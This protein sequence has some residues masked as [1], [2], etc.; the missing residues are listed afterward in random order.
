MAQSQSSGGARVLPGVT[1]E[2]EAVSHVFASRHWRSEK[3]TQFEARIR[4]VDTVMG[5]TRRNAAVEAYDGECLAGL[6]AVRDALVDLNTVIAKGDL[7]PW[8]TTASPLMA[9]ISSAYVWAGDVASDLLEL[10]EHPG[11]SSW[12]YL[13]RDLATSAADYITEFL[14]PLFRQLNEL[15]GSHWIDHALQRLRPLVERLQSEIVSLSWEL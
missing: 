3:L 5:G 4:A 2:N 10:A 12:E 9:Y 13:R 14:E 7:E 15:C 1:F 11:S 8:L 6:G